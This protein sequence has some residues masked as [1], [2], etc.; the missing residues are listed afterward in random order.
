MARTPE[1][2]RTQ[3]RMLVVRPSMTG[4]L[5]QT[6]GHVDMVVFHTAGLELPVRYRDLHP[7]G[8]FDPTGRIRLD[9]FMW[10]CQ[11]HAGD[12]GHYAVEWGYQP[13]HSAVT[14]LAEVD[15]SRP[16]MLA[17]DKAMKAEAQQYGAPGTIGVAAARLVRALK[18]DGV[19]VMDHAYEHELRGSFLPETRVWSA[20]TA[21]LGEGVRIVDE[22]AER[23]QH[24][25]MVHEEKAVA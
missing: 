5:N 3:L 19:C 22:A 12:R 1:P 15:R 9:R 23:L 20:R 13:T 11:R 24:L 16:S 6:Y 4:S 7:F 14:T 10:R 18:L 25:L 8:E 21:F 2:A 17:I